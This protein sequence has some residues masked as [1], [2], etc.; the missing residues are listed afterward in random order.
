MSYNFEVESGKTVKF[1]VGGKYCD[2]DIVVTTASVDTSNEDGLVTRSLTEYTNDRVNSVGS[3]SFYKNTAIKTVN[4]PKA[5]TIGESAFFTSSLESINAPEATTTGSA[6]FDVCK[7]LHT[8]NFPK[9][10][11]LGLYTFRDCQKLTRIVLP[12]LTKV[13]MYSCKGA[14]S[15]QYADFGLVA[16]IEAQVFY[17]CSALTTLILRKTGTITTLANTNALTST[18]IANGT[19][20]IYVPDNLIDSYKVATNWSTFAEQFKPISELEVVV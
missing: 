17:G 13:N 4:F 12:A 3:F 11:T 9:L 14:I 1:P 18:P 15:L 19:G 16:R 6:A 8:A 2:R 7:S 10:Q 20:Y 5:K